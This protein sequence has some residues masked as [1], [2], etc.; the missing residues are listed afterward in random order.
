MRTIKYI[1]LHCTA[2]PQNQKIEDILSYW[3]NSLGWKNPGYH[4]ILRPDG[5]AV[6]LFPID[7]VANGVAG[8]NK[9]AI[10]ISYIGGIDKKGQPIDNRT[11][12]QK[13][14]QI[15][16]ITKFKK[17]FPNAVVL[18]HRDFSTDQNGNGIIEK[19]EWIKSCPSFD[20]RSWMEAINYEKFARPSGIVY[21]LN[22]PLIKDSKVLEIQKALNR[23]GAKVTEDK[24]FGKE[25]HEA[26]LAFQK[27]KGLVPDGVAGPKTAKALNITL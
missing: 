14:T 3:K 25:T 18:G 24:I 5:I 27:A 20:V 4:Y 21:K 7:K 16:L 19:W 23:N 17:I 8:F 2:G 6:N 9:E 12:E 1:V 26:L 15:E 13:A 11:P 22:Y 10:H